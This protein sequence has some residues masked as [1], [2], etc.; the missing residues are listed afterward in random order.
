LAAS[1]FLISSQVLPLTSTTFTPSIFLLRKEEASREYQ[2][3]LAYQIAVRPDQ[4]LLHLLRLDKA[5]QLKKRNP[6]A[7]KKLETIPAFSLRNPTL[8]GRN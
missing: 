6:K 8:A 7:G 5:T 2:P 4:V 1:P 3:A